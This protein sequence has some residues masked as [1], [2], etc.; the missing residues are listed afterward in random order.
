[1]DS[2]DWNGVG[3]L[4]VANSRAWFPDVH[5]RGRVAV[6]RHFA[7]GLIGEIG[8]LDEVIYCS[9]DPEAARQAIPGEVADV[10]TYTAEA[11][12]VLDADLNTRA[13]RP[14]PIVPVVVLMGRLANAVKKLDRYDRVGNVEF[15]RMRDVAVP[16]LAALAVRALTI[17]RNT[18]VE[19]MAAFEAKQAECV[20]RWGV[21]V[22]DD[23]CTCW[24]CGG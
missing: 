10:L 3:R 1:M 24:A 20:K 12:F 21:P 2:F 4:A 15:E 9:S 14:V 6:I 17:A 11:G 13:R 22:H 18:D 19:P 7:L 16:T 23:Y 5:S 8:E